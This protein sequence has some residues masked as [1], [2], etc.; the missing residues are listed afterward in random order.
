MTPTPTPPLQPPTVA[1]P[2]F[3]ERCPPGVGRTASRLLR[4]AVEACTASVDAD[5]ERARLLRADAEQM[6]R[7]VDRLHAVWMTTA[8][9]TRPVT[10]PI[11]YAV[12][13]G[14]TDG[15]HTALA[16]MLTTLTAKLKEG[17]PI[18]FDR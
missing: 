14:A 5:E 4:Q 9:E 10:D 18:G 12:R 13:Y 16:E 17:L 6:F 7:L 8:H 3:I 15:D 11:V 2:V 1:P